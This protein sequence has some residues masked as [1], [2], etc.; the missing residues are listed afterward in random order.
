MKLRRHQ[1]EELESPVEF[2][3]DLRKIDLFSEL[4]PLHLQSVAELVEI[5]TARKDEEIVRE[6]TYSANLFVIFSGS[7]RATVRNRPRSTFGPGEF[8]G[9]LGMLGHTQSATVKAEDEMKL[10]AV[11]AKALKALLDEEPTIAVHMLQTLILR[12]EALM[13]RPAGELS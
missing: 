12:L 3:E 13:E 2:L 11:D 10:G 8:F 5:R 9:E 7:A 4:D 1:E 6:G